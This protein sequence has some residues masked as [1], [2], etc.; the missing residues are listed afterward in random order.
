MD[1][2]SMA[3]MLVLLIMLLL[4]STLPA[5]E[6]VDEVLATVDR[7]PILE[8]DLRLAGI[9][10]LGEGRPLTPPWDEATR[11]RLLSHR[12]DLEIEFQDLNNS[13]ALRRLGIDLGAEISRF[14]ARAGGQEKLRALLRNHH[15]SWQDLESLAQ[16]TAATR[17]WVERRLRPKIRVQ[18]TDVEAAYTR[19]I[20]LPLRLEGQQPPPLDKIEADLRRLVEEE[21]LNAAIDQWL[22]HARLQHE[23]L[24]FVK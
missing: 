9:L 17:S 7:S 14:E 5:A 10:G 1:S 8:S 6:V 3:G 15:L 21:Q 4:T 11:S 22:Q 19:E 12:I 2:D 16:R 20:V 13:G 18:R 23:V 24:R